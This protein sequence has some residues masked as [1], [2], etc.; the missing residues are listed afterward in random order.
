MAIDFC[1]TRTSECQ[2]YPQLA[3]FPYPVQSLLVEQYKIVQKEIVAGKEPQESVE[4]DLVCPTDCLFYC[5][6][7]LPYKHL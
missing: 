2:D 3:L 1:T 6:H 4:D 5:Q 7:Q